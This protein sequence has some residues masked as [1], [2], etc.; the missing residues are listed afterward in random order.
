MTIRPCRNQDLP[1]CAALMVEVF[2]AA[3]FDEDWEVPDAEA[4]LRR[5]WLFDPDGCLLADHEGEIVGLLVGYSYPWQGQPVFYLQELFVRTA[6]RR[7]GIATALVRRFLEPGGGAATLAAGG[8]ALS[9]IAHEKLVAGCFCDQLG[10]VQHPD[11]K[12]YC[13]RIK[14]GPPAA[15]E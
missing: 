1:A 4:Y 10:L 15:S 7:Q 9:M 11:Y 14:P 2:G 3:P 13:G 8:T 12:F 6:W 5:F